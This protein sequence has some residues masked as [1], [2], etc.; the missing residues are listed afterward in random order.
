[1]KKK[2]WWLSVAVSAVL[3]SGC[4][5]GGDSSTGNDSE[6]YIAF[7]K[8]PS[9]PIDMLVRTDGTAAGTQEPDDT[10]IPSGDVSKVT[11]DNMEIYQNYL[12]FTATAVI[13]HPNATV[14]IP[15]ILGKNYRMDLDQNHEIVDVNVPFSPDVFETQKAQRVRTDDGLF[16]V[17]ENNEEDRTYIKRFAPDGTM[18]IV[19]GFDDHER[20]P[21]NYTGKT[22]AGD[23]LIYF[24]VYRD[25]SFASVSTGKGHGVVTFDTTTSTFSDSLG[26]FENF[27]AGKMYYHA[28]SHKLYINGVAYDNGANH[29]GIYVFD[30]QTPNTPPVRLIPNVFATGEYLVADGRIYVA[31]SS[32]ND[33]G[34]A[35][36]SGGTTNMYRIDSD[37]NNG[38]ETLGPVHGIYHGLLT[39]DHT[40]YFIAD[41][42]LVQIH[43]EGTLEGVAHIDTTGATD[44]KAVEVDGKL[45]FAANASATGIELYRF[46]GQAA[47]RVTDINPGAGSA[48]PTHLAE[49][50]GRLV[51]QAT[52][53]GH[54]NH[55]YRYDPASGAVADLN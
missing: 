52:P 51:F 46:D 26:A 16:M 49:L 13:E 14:P 7:S 6:A 31:A 25:P 5:A 47:T 21:D 55:L 23:H 15:T 12:Y 3:I 36:A 18:G 44:G 38:F 27:L 40:V 37:N 32:V 43:H 45:Y 19:A 24:G 54:D 20:A 48:D 42:T 35:A 33:S 41:G 8:K 1:M 10:M 4:G 53:D 22:A 34:Q 2:I 39:Y 9:P 30:T 29:S 17:Y 11:I 28:A 50:N